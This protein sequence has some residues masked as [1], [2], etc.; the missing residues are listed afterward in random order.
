MKINI[1]Y[2]Y[3]LGSNTN[4]T[5]FNYLKELLNSEK[6]NLFCIDYKQ[7]EP[8]KSIAILQDFIDKHQIDIIIG[9]SYGGFLA[10]RLYGKHLKRI[11]IN[12]ALFGGYSLE[13]MNLWE[14]EKDVVKPAKKLAN[15]PINIPL[16]IKDRTYML[17]GTKDEI[18]GKFHYELSASS[19]S[20]N[21]VIMMENVHHNMTKEELNKYIVNLINGI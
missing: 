18:F 6:Y 5:K 7:H 3:G 2:I 12:P 13:T 4:S 8:L 19:Y 1:L 14:S 11:I 9:I 21:D 20:N 15:I 17:F 16:D 10:T